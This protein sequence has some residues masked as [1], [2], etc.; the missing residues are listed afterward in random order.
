MRGRQH[1]HRRGILAAGGVQQVAHAHQRIFPGRHLLHAVLGEDHR[2]L[3]ALLALH[4]EVLEAADVAHPEVVDRGVVARRDASE[5][6][7]LGPLGLGFQP[8]R[9][10]AALRAQRAGGVDRVRVVPRPR[11]KAVLPGGDG[12][13]RADIHQVAREQ[14]VDALFVEG[15]NLAAVAAVDG[16]DLRVAIH[17]GHEAAAAR[18][19]DAAVAVQH[20]RRA[21]VDVGLDALAVKRAAREVHAAGVVAELVRE[22]LQRALAAL[23]ADRAIERVIDQQEL[24]HALAAFDGLGVLR[25]HHHAFSHRRR[26]RR[27]QLA[28]L[29]DLHQADATRGVDA[30]TGVVAVIRDLDAGFNGGLEDRG[31]LRHG[32]LAAINGQRDVFHD[33]RMISGLATCDLRLATGRLWD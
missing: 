4:P 32:Q 29:F 17:F 20:Q 24:E 14:R 25:V 33:F 11:A 23:V 18:A 1:A 27:L 5:T 28:H 8:G 10:A 15:G 2:L 12:A 31:A 30:E 21:E 19:Q 22:V 16:A 26:A 3:Q 6:R 9:G 13:D 7:A